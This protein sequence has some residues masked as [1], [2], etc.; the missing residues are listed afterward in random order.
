MAVS[1]LVAPGLGTV[2]A[3]GAASHSLQ[4][5]SSEQ[6]PDEGKWGGDSRIYGSQVHIPEWQCP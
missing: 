5:Q 4:G 1:I 2:Y 3:T 6:R